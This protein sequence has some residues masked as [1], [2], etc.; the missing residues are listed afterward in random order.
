M[1]GP[2]TP[3]P[4]GHQVSVGGSLEGWDAVVIIFGALTIVAVLLWPLIRAVARRIEGGG[5]AA[6]AQAELDT[7]R[8]RVQSLEDLPPRIAELEER[9][10]FAERMLAQA[11]EPDRLPR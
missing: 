1:L 5:P 4:P 6:A 7:L 2:Q 11:R 8:A 3:V 10:E 9:L